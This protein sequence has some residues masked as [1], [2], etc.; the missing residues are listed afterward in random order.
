MTFSIPRGLTTV[1][2]SLNLPTA[3]IQ[4]SWW[5]LKI[6]CYVSRALTEL[7]TVGLRDGLLYGLVLMGFTSPSLVLSRYTYAITSVRTK[8][9]WIRR[10]SIQE[11]YIHNLLLN[12]CGKNIFACSYRFVKSVRMTFFEQWKKGGSRSLFHLGAGYIAF[13]S[14]LYRFFL[15]LIIWLINFEMLLCFG[16]S[17]NLKQIRPSTTF[18]GCLYIPTLSQISGD[19]LRVSSE[20][21]ASRDGGNTSSWCVL[22]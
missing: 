3:V 12:L 13:P 17:L 19:Y 5:I 4:F 21:W 15:K 22:R 16:L 9:V 11:S 2:W 14:K 8:N 18:V 7:K 1:G 6:S 10:E 20:G